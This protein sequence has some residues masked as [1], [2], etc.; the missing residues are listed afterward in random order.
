MPEGWE[1]KQNARIEQE[2]QEKDKGRMDM[3]MMDE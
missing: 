1:E 2:G 3:W